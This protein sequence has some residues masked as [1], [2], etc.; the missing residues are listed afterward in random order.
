MYVHE[1]L[2]KGGIM[3]WFIISA[4][5]VGMSVFA[6]RFIHYH[7]AQIVL[8]DF[9]NGIRNCIRRNNHVEAITL[10]DDATGPVAQVA[11]SAILRHDRSRSEIHEAVEAT[12]LQ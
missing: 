10:C 8:A 2:S 7:R 1:I 4:S 9:L 3:V 6:E 5:L 12:A 11:R